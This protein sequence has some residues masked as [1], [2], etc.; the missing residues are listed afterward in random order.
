MGMM[1]SSIQAEKD[2]ERKI[3]S[4]IQRI[5]QKITNHLQN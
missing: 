3:H 2:T 1:C 5:I 4:L